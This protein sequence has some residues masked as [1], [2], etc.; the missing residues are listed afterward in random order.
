MTAAA[1]PR[2]AALMEAAEPFLAAIVAA[3]GDA[4]PRL[5]FADWLSE[6][7]WDAEAAGQRWAAREG[8]YPRVGRPGGW[9]TSDA[10]WHP[11]CLL[12]ID[13]FWPNELWNS[14]TEYYAVTE[15]LDCERWFLHRCG[16]LR[17]DAAGEP[18]G[19]AKGG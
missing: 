16:E 9:F 19:E 2:R 14:D 8:K 17:W 1:R 10:E 4:L 5:I 7:G 11:Y 12:P 6:Q 13:V 18:A 3:P 15:P